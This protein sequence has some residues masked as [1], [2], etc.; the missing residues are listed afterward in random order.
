MA[1]TIREQNR[2]KEIAEAINEAVNIVEILDDLLV[3]ISENC[4]PDEVFDEEALVAWAV[5]NGYVLK[6]DDHD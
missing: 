2:R 5:E 3:A 6:D 1:T 4:Q